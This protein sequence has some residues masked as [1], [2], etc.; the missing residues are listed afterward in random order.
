[1]IAASAAAS[2]QVSDSVI[3]EQ[4]R[5]AL[6][7]AVPDELDPGAVVLIARGD[8]R[9]DRPVFQGAR[10]RAQMELGVPLAPGQIFRIA[11]ITNADH[12]GRQLVLRAG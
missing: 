6:Q 11:S 2:P 4:A 9:G 5:A 7:R 1:M 10:G 8:S 3:A 12:G